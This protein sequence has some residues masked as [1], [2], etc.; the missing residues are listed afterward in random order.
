MRRAGH[1][2]AALAMVMF[3]GGSALAG[4]GAQSPIQGATPEECQAAGKAAIKVCKAEAKADAKQCRL[5][6][7]EKKGTCKSKN[8]GCKQTAKNLKKS[9]GRGA[10]K[11]SV[12]CRVKDSKCKLWAANETRRCQHEIKANALRCE[13]Q[14]NYDVAMCIAT[15][16]HKNA[17]IPEGPCRATCESEA[18][19]RPDECKAQ[20]RLDYLTCATEKKLEGKMC[21]AKK[22]LCKEE[23]RVAKLMKRA[24][25]SGRTKNCKAGYKACKAKVKDDAKQCKAAVKEN[26][27]RSVNLNECTARCVQKAKKRSEQASRRAAKAK[28]KAEAQKKAESKPQ[29]GSKVDIRAKLQTKT[30]PSGIPYPASCQSDAVDLYGSTLQALSKLMVK[31][32]NDANRAVVMME[33]YIAKHP[34]DIA[35]IK[36]SVPFWENLPTKQQ[37]LLRKEMYKHKKLLMKLARKAAKLTRHPRIQKILSFR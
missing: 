21:G 22:K 24:G 29:P 4:G 10:S 6:S 31:A 2:S 9:M 17:P 27:C 37:K 28:A 1:L 33:A 12:D 8:K 5:E 16:T 3:F 26:T 11:I 19:T 34:E 25:M 23:N 15:L 35:C 32:N 20:N 36:L 7:K 13:S 18:A 14:I 30:N